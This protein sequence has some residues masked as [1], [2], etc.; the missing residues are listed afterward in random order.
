MR[1]VKWK[2]MPVRPMRRTIGSAAAARSGCWPISPTDGSFLPLGPTSDFHWGTNPKT[3]AGRSD[4]DILSRP[5][6]PSGWSTTT[7]VMTTMSWPRCKC[8][9]RQ[10]ALFWC[11]LGCAMCLFVQTAEGQELEPAGDPLSNHEPEIYVAIYLL[12]SLAKNRN[13]NLGGEELP[14]T[15]VRNGAGGGF[16]AGVFPAFTG[17]VL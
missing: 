15:T 3:S 8:I 7:G 1:W 5:I 6:S 2:L 16:K 12:G 10:G 4:S 9:S 17:Y 13:L 14:S 11:V